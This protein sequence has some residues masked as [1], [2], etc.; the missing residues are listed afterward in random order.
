MCMVQP[1]NRL[2]WRPGLLSYPASLVRY[3]QMSTFFHL[4]RP[5]AC[6]KLHNWPLQCLAGQNLYSES[7]RDAFPWNHHQV[8]HNCHCPTRKLIDSRLLRRSGSHRRSLESLANLRACESPWEQGYL[9]HFRGLDAHSY[10]FPKWKSIF[11]PWDKSNAMGRTQ[12]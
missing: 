11:S 2:V 1:A 3:D 7:A 8:C 4:C 5:W 6:G 12:R 10:L 9:P